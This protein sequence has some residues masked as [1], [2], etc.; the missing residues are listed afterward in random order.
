MFNRFPNRSY[1]SILKVKLS[2]YRAVDTIGSN[3]LEDP[4]KDSPGDITTV[5]GEPSRSNNDALIILL[6]KAFTDTT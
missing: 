6:S 3:I 4:A 2:P 5:N 1:A